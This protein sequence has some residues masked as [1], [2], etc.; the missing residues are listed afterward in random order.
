MNQT[1][2][3]IQNTHTHTHAWSGDIKS[4]KKMVQFEKTK[5]QSIFVQKKKKKNFVWENQIQIS[6]FIF[7]I[8]KI[9][10]ILSAN[11]ENKWNIKSR[12]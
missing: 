1:F 12:W 7:I 5:N 4:I 8:I 3:S 10:M 11:I 6:V 9:K 2:D